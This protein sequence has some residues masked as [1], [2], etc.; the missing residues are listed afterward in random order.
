MAL[1]D[2]YMPAFDVTERHRTTVAAPPAAVYAALRRTDIAASPLVR[3]LLALR[4][5]P[6][7]LRAPRAAW[8]ARRRGRAQVTLADFE[9][10]GFTVLAEDAPRELLI[11][12]DGKFW[13]PDGALCAVDAASFRGP[14]RPGTARA[15]WNFRVEPLPGG[16]ATLSTETRV[17]C[18]DAAARRRF[19]AYWLVVRP[20][21]GV[22]RR[23]MLGAVRRA[24][25]GA[26]HGAARV[27]E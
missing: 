6:T 13:T 24:A 5:A 25:E 4:A 1:I 26:A 19:R 17:R 7:A 10:R 18:A 15:A 9:R 21:S 16:G 3:A 20:W 8:R 12:L 23:A 22:I 27:N 11:G 2:D 14:M